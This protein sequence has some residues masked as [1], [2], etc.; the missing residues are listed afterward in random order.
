MKKILSIILGLSLASISSEARRWD[1]QS[2]NNAIIWKVENDIPHYDHIEMS[3][4]RMSVVLRWGVDETKSFTLERS[5]VFP[6]LRTIPNNTR[7]C[8]KHRIS[9]DIPALLS[10]NGRTLQHEEVDSIKLDGTMTVDSRWAVGRHNV[11]MGEKPKRQIRLVRTVF[12]SATLPLLCERY[13]LYNN[14]SKPVEVNVPEFSQRFTTDSSKGVDGSYMIAAEVIG[15]GLNNLNPGDS[16]VFGAIFQAHVA[17]EPDFTPDLTEELS[18]RKSF[19]HN[20]IME[21][22]ILET[23]DEV[24]NT[25]FAFAKLRA[26]ESIY[27]TRG[28]YMHGPGGE[29]YYAAIWANDQAEYVN[30][31]FPY[32]GYGIGNESALNSFRHFA[33]FMNDEYE[34]LPS[35]IIAEGFDIWNGKG[36]RGDAAMI[37]YGASRYA[38]ALGD[39]DVADGLWPLIEWCLTF[40]KRKLN[41]DGVVESDTDELEDRFP[42]GDANLCTSTLYYDAL[43]NASILAKEL[44]KPSKTYNSYKSDSELLADNIEKHFAAEMCGYDT[45]RYYEGNDK[46]RSWIC[47]PLIVGLEEHRDGTIAALLGPELMTEDGLLTEQGSRT[48]WDRATL[49]ALR[50]IYMAGEADKATEYLHHYSERRLLG[51]HVPYPIE[52]WPEGSQRHLSAESGL[53][54][55]IFIEGIFGIHPAGF[56]SFTLTPSMPGAWSTMSL[57]NIKAYG[58]TFDIIID[59]LP[60]GYRVTV[61]QDGEKSLV[62][63]LKS[64]KTLTVKL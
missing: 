44:G 55:R 57:K 38:L 32:L 10:V 33:R 62:R 52:A 34:P 45:Y 15:S 64:G 35:S 49:Y 7:G 1:I 25:E 56:R 22:L 47:M 53:Y 6:M 14:A 48:F 12:P 5:L 54:C 20:D 59:R 39:K 51:D 17:N 60:S 19:V 13:V 30:P 43:R 40:C 26:S 29:S 27:K 50:G 21:N 18:A 42:S 9:T 16:I 2:G 36:D 8:V 46:L 63:T 3:G 11:R 58:S 41:E 24:M 31:F 37:A 28:G 23:P 4:E 61:A